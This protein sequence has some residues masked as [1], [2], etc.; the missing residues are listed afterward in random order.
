MVQ[1]P[2]VGTRWMAAERAA[3]R[4]DLARLRAENARLR[5]ENQK[6]R[7]ALD[8]RVPRSN[9]P[10]RFAPVELTAGTSVGPWRPRGARPE[11]G[12]T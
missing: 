9:S 8:A 12:L 1:A 7:D 6:L 2:T 10:R 5:S 3:M 11:R 4:A